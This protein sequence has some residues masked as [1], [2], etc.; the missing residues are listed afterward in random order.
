LIS[1]SCS[2]T[3]PSEQVPEPFREGFAREALFSVA[4]SV[5]EGVERMVKDFPVIP[6]E[7]THG[8]FCIGRVVGGNSDIPSPGTMPEVGDDEGGE[9]PLIV[10]EVDGAFKVAEG[11]G[12][13]GGLGS[14][15]GNL[16]LEIGGELVIDRCA[17]NEGVGEVLG[18]L[19][20][21]AG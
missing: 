2:N 9:T 17:V 1:S 6:G 4:G 21:V 13:G 10:D 12:G 8:S 19:L 14:D 11:N 20:E 7:S 16:G 5:G 3:S 18:D 15:S